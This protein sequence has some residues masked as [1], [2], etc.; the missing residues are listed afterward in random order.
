MRLFAWLIYA[1]FVA[2]LWLLAFGV[3]IPWQTPLWILILT[4]LC[5]TIEIAVW[6]QN[7]KK[8]VETMAEVIAEQV[9][10]APRGYR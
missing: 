1:S 6:S 9:K 7:R 5:L 3:A 8:F 2:R 10:K 4:A